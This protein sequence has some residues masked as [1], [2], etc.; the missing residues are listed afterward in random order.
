[1]FSKSLL[2][3]LG[4]IALLSAVANTAPVADEIDWDAHQWMA[5][6]PDDFRSPCPGLNALANHGFLPRDGRGLNASV[7]LDAALTGYNV[8]PEVLSLAVKLALLT[9]NDP[10]TFTLD[11]IK[12]HNTIESDASLS[13][14]DFA[15]GDN[16]HFNETIFSTLANSNPG[17]DFYDTTSAGQVQQI[18]LADSEARN[19][20]ITNTQKEIFFRSGAS[21]L[22]LGVMGDPETGKA[23]KEFVQVLFREERLPI[24]EGWHRSETPINSANQLSLTQLIIAA[25]NWTSSG[26]CPVFTLTPDGLHF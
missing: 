12:L 18:R 14:E 16:V 9:S 13:R 1:M 3:F 17:F 4:T 2:S 26:G 21:A 24:A 6:G 23:P 10:S 25:S 11:D 5:P 19:P 20:N 7:V 8:Q 22:Y 15:I